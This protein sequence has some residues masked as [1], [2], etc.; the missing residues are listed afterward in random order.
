[1][2]SMPP[3]PKFTN[4]EDEMA[5]IDDFLKLR[6]YEEEA[7]SSD[8]ERDMMNS[9]IDGDNASRTGGS[10]DNKM[11]TALAE[12]GELWKSGGVAV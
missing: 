10:G 11:K 7:D 8:D 9:A 12:A 1:M 2:G 6:K 4:T 3:T 5:N